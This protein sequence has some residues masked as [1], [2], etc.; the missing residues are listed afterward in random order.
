MIAKAY[1]DVYV[2]QIALNANEVQSVRAVLEAAAYPGPSLILAYSTCI[3]HG[4]DL[5]DTAN[6]MKEAVTSGHWP[7]YR[8]HP[9]PQPGAEPQFKLDSKAPST[10]VAD[11]YASETRYRSVGRSNP[12]LAEKM[13]AQAQEDAIIRFKHYEW[14]SNEG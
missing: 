1:R 10:S 4:I 9:E 14:L 11:F 3:A 12:E 8:Y 7:L 6:H 2:A 5:A 13:A